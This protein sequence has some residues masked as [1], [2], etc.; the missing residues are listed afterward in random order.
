V[1][2]VIEVVLPDVVRMVRCHRAV[3]AV[4]LPPQPPLSV[5]R[6]RPPSD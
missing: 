2:G 5:L 6:M 4:H 3:S 1:P